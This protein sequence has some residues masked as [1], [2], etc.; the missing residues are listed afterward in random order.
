MQMILNDCSSNFPAANIYDGKVLVEKFLMVYS[1]IGKF[2]KNDSVIIEKDY[3]NIMLAEDYSI[4][5]WRNDKTVDIEIKR[6][7]GRFISKATVYSKTE[8]FEEK[9]N[10]SEV[11]V[12]EKPSIGCLVAYLT[13]NPVISFISDPIW[14]NS[15]I[16]GK[17]QYLDEDAEKFISSD[18]VRIKNISNK[19][20]AEFF[21][22]S[23]PNFDVLP[24]IHS[25]T[26]LWNRRNELFPNLVF[27][28]CVKKQLID[29][30]DPFH[31]TQIINKLFML[32][33]Y[34]ANFDG[35]FD[36]KALL[37][38]VPSSDSTLKKFKSMYTFT[39]PENKDLLFSWHIKFTGGYAG[40]IYFIPAKKGINNCTIGHINGH[41]PTIK[42]N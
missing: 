42:Y 10:I 26:E 25:G 37:G 23:N 33:K 28:E 3:N 39:T 7:F 5:H 22:K 2:I 20:N 24:S 14:E 18:D 27:C 16:D 35:V 31:L 34:F 41:L 15:F 11:I 17:Y 36:Q 40:R 6:I 32:E 13:D 38:S 29:E 1:D 12:E 19:E 9:F 21:K 8:E 30:I 4:L